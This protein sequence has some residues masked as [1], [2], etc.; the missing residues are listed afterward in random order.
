MPAKWRGWLCEF[1][2]F[3]AYDKPAETLYSDFP[4]APNPTY[5]SPPGVQ[6]K[7]IA[8]MISTQPSIQLKSE[9][10]M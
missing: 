9:H 10:P 1:R 7:S 5:E 6:S 4:T 8:S 2:N 3:L